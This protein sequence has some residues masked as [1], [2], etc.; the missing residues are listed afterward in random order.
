MDSFDRWVTRMEQI[1]ICCAVPVMFLTG[2]LQVVS[3]FII[4]APIAWSEQL[5]T[6]L[7]VWT[8]YLGASVALARRE[9]FQVDILVPLLSPAARKI[10]DI[11]VDAVVILFCL[12]MIWKG[13]FLF[14][15]TANQS[16]A[17]LPFSKRWAYLCI[18]VAAFGMMIHSLTH[19]W[20][21]WR[22]RAEK[23]P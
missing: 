13:L 23:T 4:K 14:E 2:I 6:V 5:L 9:H 15:R 11:A 18:P 10:L 1:L 16:L 19:V 22:A 12:F 20:N 21:E 8:S 17:M 7:F 3:R